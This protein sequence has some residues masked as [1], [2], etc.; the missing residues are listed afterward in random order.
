MMY[1]QSVELDY[2]RFAIPVKKTK[3]QS[4]IKENIRN[5]AKE[6]GIAIDTHYNQILHSRN[7]YEIY[8]RVPLLSDFNYAKRNEETPH[9]VIKC[10]YMHGSRNFLL[11]ECKGHPYSSKEWY[12]VRLW[13]E[14]I[15]GYK[16]LKKHQNNIYITSFDIAIGVD[17]SIEN[18][19]FDFVWGQKAGWFTAPSGQLETIYIQPHNKSIEVCIYNRKAKVRNRGVLKKI[20]SPSR[21]EL[22]F[23]RRKIAL[24]DFFNTL[25]FLPNAFKRSRVYNLEKIV[26]QSDLDEDQIIAL[27]SA[28][29]VPYLRKISKYRREKIRK[30]IKPHLEPTIDFSL[31]KP[32]WEKYLKKVKRMR[33]CAKYTARKYDLLRNEFIFTYFKK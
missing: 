17:I 24:D 28:G 2:I 1:L 11:I 15:L 12:L 8:C 3:E 10:S 31:A 16:L 29:L 4:L 7:G 22:R 18:Y 23:G 19:L 6:L 30:Q 9:L 33:P 5:M 13:L 26:T 32:L 27:Q 14:R 20:T 25:D 21:I